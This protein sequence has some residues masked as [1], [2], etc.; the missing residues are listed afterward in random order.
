MSYELD[1][2]DVDERGCYD[3]LPSMMSHDNLIL[4]PCLARITVPSDADSL[5][6]RCEGYL[7]VVTSR[8]ACGCRIRGVLA[9]FSAEHRYLGCCG[10]PRSVSYDLAP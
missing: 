6:G 4:Q 3:P 9:L 5:Q 1:I 2:V 8:G 10:L 7:V